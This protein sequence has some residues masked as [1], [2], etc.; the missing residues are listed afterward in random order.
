M[1]TIIIKIMIINTS[2]LF[3]E[4]ETNNY[5]HSIFYFYGDMNSGWKNVNKLSEGW[6]ERTNDHFYFGT[7]DC[8]HKTYYPNEYRKNRGHVFLSSQLCC[9]VHVVV[10]FFLV[11]SICINALYTRPPPCPVN[12]KGTTSETGERGL[13]DGARRMGDDGEQSEDNSERRQR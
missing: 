8:T 9:R 4:T 11:F 13:G 3:F 7:H 2:F 6:A 12:R 1:D 5:V 10:F